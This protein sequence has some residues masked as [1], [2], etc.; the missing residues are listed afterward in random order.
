MLAWVEH[1]GA[2][3]QQLPTNSF[4]SIIFGVFTQPFLSSSSLP[5][6]LVLRD[7]ESKGCKSTHFLPPIPHLQ[8]QIAPGQSQAFIYAEPVT[9]VMHHSPPVTNCS[10]PNK[11]RAS[12]SLGWMYEAVWLVWYGNNNTGIVC[13][14]PPPF[15]MWIF[16]RLLSPSLLTFVGVWVCACCICVCVIVDCW[17]QAYYFKLS[18]A[19]ALIPVFF[20]EG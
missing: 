12:L 13:W 6:P 15:R 10:L 7:I 19:P 17:L 20:R 5:L 2:N 1:D 3:Q 9:G 18:P 14:L 8:T 4:F 16:Y 11:R